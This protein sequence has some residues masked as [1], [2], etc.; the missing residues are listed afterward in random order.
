[1]PAILR[2]DTVRQCH[3]H[4]VR[5]QDN[6]GGPVVRCAQR[7]QTMTQDVAT[8]TAAQSVGAAPLV[9]F[10]LVVCGTLLLCLL[11]GADSEGPN[12]LYAAGRTLGPRRNALA[13]TGDYISVLTLVTTTG[14]VALNGYDGMTVAICA[15][16]ALGVLLLLAQPLRN[17]GRYTLGDTLDARFPGNRTR[18]AGVVATLCFCLPMAVLQLVA[19]GSA[20]AALVGLSHTGAAQICTAFI[21]AMMICAAAISG[22][23]GNTMLQAIKTVVLLVAMTALALF[24]LKRFSWSVTNLLDEAA[25]N[26]ADPAGFFAPGMFRGAGWTGRLDLVSTQI[27]VVLGT[28]V[29]PHL[30]MRINAADHATSARRSVKYT[31]AMV[32]AFTA[33]ATLLAL[34]AA[35]L[36]GGPNIV[37]SDPR[38]NTSLLLLVDRI[39]DGA[40]GGILLSLT[41]SAVFLTS[42]TVV[43]ALTLSA[44]ASLA[45][46]IFTHIVRHGGRTRP[47][48][49]V[50]AMRWATPAVCLLVVT[51]SVALQGSD[52]HFL[53]Q[54]AASAAASAI[55]PALLLELFWKGYTSTGMLWSIYGGLGCSLLLQ[56]FG[57]TTSGS[58]TAMFP[59]AD[60]SWYPLGTA[61]LVAIP[62]AFVLGFVASRL[63]TGPRGQIPYAELEVKMLTGVGGPADTAG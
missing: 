45:H 38:G 50:T 2:V 24:V 11:F 10:L 44:A 14:I 56:L 47:G 9:A 53:A 61:G 37:A 15:V 4:D 49:E 20:V 30:L 6:P 54:F 13:L 8:T 46:D 32:G 22:M 7:S 19:A 23:R 48:S 12:D 35:A 40:S 63:T 57:P 18:I 55:L 36:V 27:T 59:S 60:F 31:I 39:A 17:I 51:V 25:S 28:A 43:T 41:V 62:T 5:L 1:M 34:G 3:P 29:A 33:L 26:S 58:P 21:G 16:G 52:V 42:L